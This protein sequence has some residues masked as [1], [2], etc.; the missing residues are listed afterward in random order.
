M[1]PS[2]T[3]SRPCRSTLNGI[4]AASGKAGALIG[5]IVFLPIA[6]WLGNDKVMIACAAIS[7][8][9]TAL[10]L[11]LDDSSEEQSM[12]RVSSETQL[13]SLVTDGARSQF[14]KAESMP[15]IFDHI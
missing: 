11:F 15:S 4:C 8:L 3:F 2:I 7:V 14:R 10:T 5:S 9:A 1:M 13:F 6:N 12:M